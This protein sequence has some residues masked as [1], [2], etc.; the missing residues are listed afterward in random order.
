[1]LFL[2]D[3]PVL[4]VKF[5][6]SHRVFHCLALQGLFEQRRSIRD[7]NSRLRPLFRA[8]L[9]GIQGALPRVRYRPTQKPSRVIGFT[10][11]YRSANSVRFRSLALPRLP[12]RLPSTTTTWPAF[13]SAWF[14]LTI[15]FAAPSG[16]PCARFLMRSDPQEFF[17]VNSKNLQLSCLIQRC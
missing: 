4:P 9:L 12:S 16:H 17:K 10:P 14:R 5:L 11:Y 15:G 8:F 7:T 6:P 2:S 1:M 13:A 3:Y